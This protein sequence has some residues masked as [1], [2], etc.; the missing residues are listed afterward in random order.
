LNRESPSYKGDLIVIVRFGVESGVVAAV[1]GCGACAVGA[2]CCVAAG[3]VFVFR[4]DVRVRVVAVFS[5]RKNTTSRKAP[6]STEQPRSE[7]VIDYYYYQD[8][9]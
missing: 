5:E 2:G 8:F 7:N 9:P 1:S 4:R 6:P 3:A